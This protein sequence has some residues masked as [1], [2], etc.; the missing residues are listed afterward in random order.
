MELTR[1]IGVTLVFSVPAIIG[2]GLAW[3]LSEQWSVVF[4]YLSFLGFILLAFLFNPEQMVN[5]VVGE[6]K[7]KR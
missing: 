1:K 3:I 7:I 4:A 6:K 5:K 2:G